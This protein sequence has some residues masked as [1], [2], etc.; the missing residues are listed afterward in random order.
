MPDAASHAQLGDFALTLVRHSVY[1]WDGGALFGVVPKTLWSRITPA[2]ELNR[3]PLAFNCYLIRTG[4][5]T[6]QLL[7]RLA[8]FVWPRDTRKLLDDW[9]SELGIRR[10]ERSRA[11]AKERQSQQQDPE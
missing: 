8:G 7:G 11:R 9:R 2:D 10:R 3:V 1:W 6:I 4:D 5:H